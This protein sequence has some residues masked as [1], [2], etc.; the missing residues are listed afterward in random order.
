MFIRMRN[1]ELLEFR[2]WISRGDTITLVM[3]NSQKVGC[4]HLRWA[5]REDL[6]LFKLVDYSIWYVVICLGVVIYPSRG[7]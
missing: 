3:V 7:S 6:C 1:L 4:R 2:D 5:T